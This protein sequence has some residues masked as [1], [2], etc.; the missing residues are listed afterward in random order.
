MKFYMK[1]RGRSAFSLIELS[2]VILIIGIIAAGITQ[3]S[4]LVEQFKLTSARSLTK[5]SPVTGVKGLSLWLETTLQGSF[6]D[7]EDSDNANVTAW[8][9]SNPQAVSKA[10]AE[11][12]AKYKSSCINGLPCINFTGS[13]SALTIDANIFPKSDNAPGIVDNFTVFVVLQRT[14]AD[15]PVIRTDSAASGAGSVGISVTSTSVAA[16]KGGSAQT[17]ATV[18]GGLTSPQVVRMQVKNGDVSF[19]INDS[20]TA[21][22]GGS[23]GTSVSP[24]GLIGGG[25]FQGYVSE[26]I[27]FSRVVNSDE[28][29]EVAQYLKKKW[30]IK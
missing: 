15:G 30:G 8:F 4:R 26:I 22:S 9:D 24:S 17:A 16:S 6:K 14:S 1:N 3:S 5:S 29:V 7:G 18:S 27:V 21:L 13:S 19:F 28:G 25:A 11:G 20:T 10:N 12:T 23:L 2:I